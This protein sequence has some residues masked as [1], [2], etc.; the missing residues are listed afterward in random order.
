MKFFPY[1]ILLEIICLIIA[2]FNIAYKKNGW[3]RHFIWFLSLTIVVELFSQA[4]IIL[5]HGKGSNHWLYNL[6][7]PIQFFFACWILFK[8]CIMYF[9]CKPVIVTGLAI[10]I[11]T[12]LSE[13]INSHFL[14][15]SF[16]A[17]SFSSTWIVI[18]CCLYYYYLLKQDGY[19]IIAKDAPFWF[20]T[21]NFFFYF[22]TTSCNFFYDYLKVINTNQNIPVRYVIYIVLNFILYS[23]WSYA[24][25]CKHRQT[26]SSF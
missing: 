16:I 23:C 1:S 2:I 14:E 12:Y 7:M 9:N 8:I 15:Y 4:I 5:S 18:I 19:I 25:I 3:W 24:F 13:S 22:G 20:V 21:G 11:I 6:F 17:N 26:I 10:F